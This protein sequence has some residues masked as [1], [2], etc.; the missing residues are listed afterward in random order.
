MA[1]VSN[2]QM[3]QEGIW[4]LI[5]ITRECLNLLIV[6]LWRVQQRLSNWKTK[7]LSFASRFNLSKAILS[8]IP[9][10]TMQIVILHRSICDKVD[11]LCKSFLWRDTI[12]EKR[13]HRVCQE[14]I[15]L[16]KEFKG[17]GLRQACHVNNAF[18]IKM[19]WELCTNNDALW[20]QAIRANIIMGSWGF[21]L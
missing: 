15:Y 16:P 9:M 11:Q 5:F 14:G 13:A 1:W 21:L 10:Y 2:E 3:T 17:L 12:D 18:M 4:G 20:V 19:A 8:S 6:I 7:N